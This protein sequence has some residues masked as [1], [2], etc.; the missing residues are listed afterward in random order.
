MERGE[1]INS[2]QALSKRTGSTAITRRRI[3]HPTKN[4][5]AKGVYRPLGGVLKGKAQKFAWE[6]ALLATTY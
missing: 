5:P 6:T 2:A 1:F 4:H 3:S